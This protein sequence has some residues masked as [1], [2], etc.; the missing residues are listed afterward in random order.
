MYNDDIDYSF[1]WAGLFIKVIIFVVIILLAIWLISIT[2]FKKES[3]DFSKNLGI[4]EQAAVKYFVGDKLPDEKDDKTKLTLE[5][6]INQKLVPKLDKNVKK[7]CDLEESYAL[8][9][10]KD[11]YIELLVR[12]TCGDKSEYIKSSI[13]N[14]ECDGEDCNQEENNNSNDNNQNSSNSGNGSV[15]NGNGSSSSGNSSSNNGNSSSSGNSSSNNSSGSGSSTGGSSSSKKL[16][17][18]YVKVDKKYTA[19]QLNKISGTNVETKTDYVQVADFCPVESVEYYSSGY[20]WK[21]YTSNFTYTLKLLDIPRDAKNVKINST[22]YFN[23]DLSMYDSYLRK[24]NVSMEGHNSVNG[25]E[26][27]SA[28][29]FRNSS[30][31][32][33]NFSFRVGN[34]YKLSNGYYVDVTVYVSNNHNVSVYYASNLRGY[35]YFTP[36]YFVGQYTDTDNCIKDFASNGNKYPSSERVNS[37]KERATLY[38]KYT[39]EK[40]Y[41]NVIW[42]VKSSLSGYVKTGKSEWR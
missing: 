30:L 28:S 10:N 19:W 16:Y 11:N 27:S 32:S 26:I 4:M 18:Q 14:E 13:E 24:N 42:S 1:N 39:I 35:V 3:I 22:K 6:M 21:D 17:Y 12:L 9:T 8:A 15:D 31:K 5:S 25:I 38:R 40:D 37:R 29:A 34:P 20:V 41:N 36:I 33:N 2:F 7:S 23:N